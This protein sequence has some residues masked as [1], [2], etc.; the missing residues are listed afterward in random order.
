MG[1][2][3][4]DPILST[5]PNGSYVVDFEIITDR[6]YKR[7]DGEPAIERTFLPMKAWDSGARKIY[8]LFRRGDKILVEAAAR[9]KEN[10][11]DIIFRVS[12]FYP[13]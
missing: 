2:L 12:K 4:K 10:T 1:V 6:Y 9:N 11:S 3:T 5:D 7:S 8:E 13:L